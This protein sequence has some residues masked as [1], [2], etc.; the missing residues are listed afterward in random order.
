MQKFLVLYMA[1]PEAFRQMMSQ[2]TP[3]QQRAGMEAWMTWMNKNQK[4]I[5]DGG[6]PLGKAMRIDANGAKDTTNSLGG[7]SI[8]QA[9]SGA[10]AAQLFNK[11]HP[12]LHVPGAWIEVTEIKPI[13]GM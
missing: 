11:Q 7:Y 6:A 4:Q 2:S 10:E 9:V 13:P 5:V 3:E 8:V 1:S 12:H